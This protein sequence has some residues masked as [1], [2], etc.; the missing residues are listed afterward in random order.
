MKLF[1]TT[2]NKQTDKLQTLSIQFNILYTTENKQTDKTS[3]S[4]N[5][6]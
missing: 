2:E 5:S 1:Y 6:I 4:I 3:D